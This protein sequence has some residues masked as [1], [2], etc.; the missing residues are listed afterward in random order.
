MKVVG[1]SGSADDAVCFGCGDALFFQFFCYFFCVYV[2]VDTLDNQL[3]GLL[4]SGG[5]C[6]FSCWA[7][8]DV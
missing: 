1:L 5:W 2:G 6:G 8:C 4:V 7:V 3:F